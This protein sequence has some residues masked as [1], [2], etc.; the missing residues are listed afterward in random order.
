MIHVSNSGILFTAL[1]PFHMFPSDVAILKLHKQCHCS[2][3]QKRIVS[4]AREKEG[5]HHRWSLNG[6]FPAVPFAIVPSRSSGS[7]AEWG[8]TWLVSHTS[9][10]RYS[11]RMPAEQNVC[12]CLSTRIRSMGGF[13]IVQEVQSCLL[14]S[15]QAWQKAVPQCFCW[16]LLV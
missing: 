4:V 8:G 14:I 11:L 3:F 16:G 2:P 10:H 15:W 6:S 13:V 9:F 1:L 7:R 5:P 12:S